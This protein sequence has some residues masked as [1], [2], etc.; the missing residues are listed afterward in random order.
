MTFSSSLSRAPRLSF[1]VL[2]DAQTLMSFLAQSK[3]SVSQETNTLLILVQVPIES[4]KPDFAINV[5]Y[6]ET[7]IWKCL[8][9]LPEIEVHLTEQMVVEN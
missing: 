9:N 4:G 6:Q 2:V 5:E 1:E 8:Q 3:F 7:N